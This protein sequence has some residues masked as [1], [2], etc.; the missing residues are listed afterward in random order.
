MASKV[1]MSVEDYLRS[2]FDGPDCD[3][4]DGDIVERNVGE[5]LHADLQGL[6]YELLKGWPGL[7][8]RVAVEIRVQTCPTRFRVADVAAWLPGP[9]LGRRVPPRPPFLAVEVLSPEDRITRV[10]PIIL[11]YLMGGVNWV[12]LIDPYEQAALVYSPE[13]PLGRLVDT[14]YTEEPSIRI[15]LKDLFGRLPEA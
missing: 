10:Q 15:A 4:V 2:S 9:P 14:L 7:K 6:I 1:H 5:L 12:W 8:L 11:E 3:Y 13:N